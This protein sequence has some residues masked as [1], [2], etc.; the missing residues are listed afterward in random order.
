MTVLV[1]SYY[2]LFIFVLTETRK[3]LKRP[4][5]SRNNWKPVKTTPQ[6]VKRP[7]T[8]RN[9]KIGKS[10]IFYQLSFFKFQAQMP[11]QRSNLLMRFYLYPILKV[12]ISNL[13]LLFKNFEPKYPNLVFW[14][15]KNQLSSINEISHLPYFE[16]G[17]FK[18]VIGFR[19]F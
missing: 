16:C 9:F 13:S 1:A 14:V 6:N 17:N 4:E 19:K 8:T 5:T 10:R 18:S 3:E 2:S 15:K 11:K 12:L 7:E